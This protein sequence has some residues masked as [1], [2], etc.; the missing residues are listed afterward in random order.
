VTARPPA[1]PDPRPPQARRG[2][3]LDAEARDTSL[4]L[5]G[6][7]RRGRYFALQKGEVPPFRRIRIQVARAGLHVRSYA[8]YI[9]APDQT[10][11]AAPSNGRI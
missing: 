7:F 3:T 2:G 11:P 5:A 6:P 10:D 8:G 1:I 9:A 4:I